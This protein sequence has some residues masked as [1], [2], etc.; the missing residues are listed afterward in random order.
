MSRQSQRMGATGAELLFVDGFAGPGCYS[1][2]EDGSPILAVKSVLNHSLPIPVPVNFL[3]VEKDKERCAIL[4][5]NIQKLKREIE[6]SPRIK[7]YRVEQGDC[8]KILN[9]FFDQRQKQSRPLGP[10]LFFLDQCGFCDVSMGLIARIMCQPLCEVFSYLNWDH[11]SRFLSDES[12]WSAIDRAFGGSQWRPVLDL[13]HGERAAFMLRTYKAT[14]MTSGRSKHV[15]QFAMCDDDGRLLYWLFFCTNNL[16]GLEEMK[17]AMWKVDPS[18]GFRFSDSDDPSQ[19]HL[20]S[21]YTK[22]ILADELGL[23]F[24]GQ[25]L[26]V[27]EVRGFVL[28]ETPG[29]LF[30]DCLNLMEKEE[31]LRPVDAPPGRKKG[32]FPDESMHIQ[33][34]PRT[35]T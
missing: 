13:E 3:F 14:L 25:I 26:T 1:G 15:W 10:G 24:G 7:S 35:L 27:G 29:Y 9:T 8:E 11:M 17:K 20:F 12:K 22:R 2:G 5:A 33:F 30:K 16:R 34:L 28:T 19:L 32:T 21:G 4:K 6:K 18:G 23:H 31:R